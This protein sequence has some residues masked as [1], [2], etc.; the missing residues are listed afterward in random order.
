MNIYGEWPPLTRIVHGIRTALEENG[1][2]LKK[3]NQSLAAGFSR[4]LIKPD[5]LIIRLSA[6]ILR[7]GFQHLG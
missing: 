5:P 4:S 2:M 7:Q 3:D 6:F 1:R